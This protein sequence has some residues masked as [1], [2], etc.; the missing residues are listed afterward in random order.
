VSTAERDTHGV[1]DALLATKRQAQ[2]M[3][4][5]LRMQGLEPE[6]RN[7]EE[8]AA[9]LSAQ[10]D[11]LLTAEMTAWEAKAT[12]LLQRLKS[13]NAGLDADIRAVRKR[14]GTAERVVKAIGR[15]DDVVGI[16]MGLLA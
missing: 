6:A 12:G 15:L 2:R 13:I 9:A 10:V 4:I 5:S 14:V 1:I 3:A 7:I 11:A 16:V 8:K